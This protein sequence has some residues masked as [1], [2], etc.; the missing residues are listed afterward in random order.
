MTT[1]TAP[2]AASAEHVGM[3]IPWYANDTL[4]AAERQ[5]VE[6]HT[7][8]CADCRASLEHEQRLAELLRARNETVDCAPQSGWA[9]LAARLDEPK[10]ATRTPDA[11]AAATAPR[12]RGRMF[13]YLQLARAAAVAVLALALFFFVTD[14]DSPAYRTLTH[15]DPGIAPDVPTL[16][17]AFAPATPSPRIRAL[18]KQVDGTIRSGPSAQNVYTVELARSATSSAGTLR[19]AADWLRAQPEVLLAEPIGSSR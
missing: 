5:S 17:V 3:L 12:A 7:A 6:R 13:V 10:K 1:E 16:R 2:P 4:S 15:P 18:L 11:V 9:R 14:R 8:L 19:Q